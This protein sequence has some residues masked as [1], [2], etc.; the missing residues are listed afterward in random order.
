MGKKWIVNLTML[1]VVLAFLVSSCFMFKAADDFFSDF[2]LPHTAITRTPATGV[3]AAQVGMMP[4]LLAIETRPADK[5]QRK[6]R[7]GRNFR[8]RG[9]GRL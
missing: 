4:I 8:E 9:F 2:H 6:P 5:T 7:K 3:P 1:I